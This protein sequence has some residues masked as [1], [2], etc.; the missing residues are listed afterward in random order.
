MLKAASLAE[1]KSELQTLP[2]EELLAIC[3]RLARF[4]RDNKELIGFLLF[5]AHNIDSYTAQLKEMMEQEFATVNTTNVWFAKKTIR[6]ILR[7]ANK[8]ARFAGNKELEAALHIHFLAELK[9]L[10][11]HI[12]STPVMDKLARSQHQKARKL[13]KGL[14]EDLQH[15]YLRK[16]DGL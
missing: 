9:K 5:E 6:K 11:A 1:I 15:D 14:H 8:Y 4:K 10:P 3:L 16:L 12:T 7:M 2:Q 13:I